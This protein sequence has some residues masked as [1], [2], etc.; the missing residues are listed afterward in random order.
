V[1]ARDDITWDTYSRLLQTL[2][3]KGAK[4]LSKELNRIKKQ[5]KSFG[6]RR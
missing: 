2:T 1:A 3:P 6:V 4:Q 5:T